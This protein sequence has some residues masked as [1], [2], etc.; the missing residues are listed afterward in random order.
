[1]QYYISLKENK[2]VIEDLSSKPDCALAASLNVE[3]MQ[4]GYMMD[5]NLFDKIARLPLETAGK[6]YSCVLQELL[7]AKGADVVYKPFYT[8]F[9]QQVMEMNELDLYFN[10]IVHY[11]SYGKWRPEDKEDVRMI[12]FEK[13]DYIML[14]PMSEEEFKSIFTQKISSN[15][16]ISEDDKMI[17]EWFI[18]NYVDLT[19]PKEIPFKENLCL[20]AAK[21][22]QKGENI[23]GCIN[24]S[25]DVLRIATYLSQGDISLASNTKFVSL[26]RKTRKILCSVL[27]R[28]ISE[29]DI[30]RHKNK[31]IRLFHNL[32]VG[33]YSP[34]I[35][36]IAA[37]FRNNEK[38]KTFNSRI[39]DAIQKRDIKA[40]TEM[41]EKRP[42]DFARRLDH[43]LRLSG[44]DW[45]T[46]ID[47]FTKIV[48]EI[49]TRVLLQLLGHVKTRNNV[50]DKR[51]VFPKGM[52][53]KAQIIRDE[54]PPLD[55][56]C[57]SK[58]TKQIQQTLIRRFFL[59]PS[60]G[61]V[62]VDPQLAN[63]PLPSQQRSAS[64]ALFNV[65][66][67]TRL[68][69]GD[70]NILRFFVYWI[71]KDIDLSASL[72]NE[73]FDKIEHISYTKIKS[74][75]YQACHSGD[76][77]DAPRG[78]SEFID[79][80]IDQALS[81]GAR[82]VVV[83]VYVYSGPYF[84]EHEECYVGWMTRKEIES[85]EIYSPKTVQQKVDLRSKSRNVV[86]CIFDLKE[87]KMIWCD[88]VTKRR[89]HKPNNI[90][91]NTATIEET[92]QAI[93]NLNNKTNLQEL[94]KLHALARGKLVDDIREADII[95]DI[96]RAYKITDIN[97]C[98]IIDKC[99]QENEEEVVGYKELSQI[100]DKPISTL[101]KWQKQGVLPESNKQGKNLVWKKKQ[102]VDLLFI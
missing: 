88:L 69:F 14:S 8:N 102:L 27:D 97:S 96:N 73:D 77:V 20:V 17:V 75:K 58:L 93:T 59:L 22:L 67:G 94:F 37:K 65:G 23:S 57:C 11:W 15:D 43:L 19:Y 68:D 78:A 12:R 80:T 26:P 42:G 61:K 79:I 82:Y 33:E 21:L 86:P 90:E 36:A 3:L 52:M 6:L 72:H 76:I 74:D 10:A 30:N 70:K 85:K 28:V 39:E 84:S 35:F 91:S 1:M 40:A 31:W 46:I 38:I 60:L 66:R 81:C 29:E 92:I 87:R 100:L 89:F 9:P 98:F 16:S 71:G 55:E 18:E 2:I 45:Q 54:L 25:T 4:L 51:V 83:N 44:K 50:V 32:H 62:W 5:K 99:E 53:Q 34:K 63:C 41:L 13:V 49:S 48:D 64:Q 7:K 56:N 47:S 24:T 95:F 101:R